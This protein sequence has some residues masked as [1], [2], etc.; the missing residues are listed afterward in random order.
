MI[1]TRIDKG[2]DVTTTSVL[3][4]PL[5]IVDGV[6]GVG[7]DEFVRITLDSGEQRHGLVLEVNRGLAVVQVMEGTSGMDPAGVRMA[8]AGRPLHIPVGPEW[9][10]RVCNGRG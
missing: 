4:G 5:A 6:S 1:E 7:W 9:L 2:I 10:G 3:R 8:F